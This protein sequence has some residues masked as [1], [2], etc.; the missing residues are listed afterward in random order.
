ML[1]M[2][3]RE[4]N[5]LSKN[6]PSDSHGSADIH[7][8]NLVPCFV[9]HIERVGK[10][11]KSR[12]IHQDIDAVPQAERRLD[13][14]LGGIIGRDIDRDRGSL[15]AD[16]P[17]FLGGLLERLQMAAYQNDV[18]SPVGQGFGD[19]ESYSHTRS[20]DN[21]AVSGRSNRSREM[22]G[23]GAFMKL[24]ELPDEGC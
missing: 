6:G 1:M 15:P 3:P 22:S 14:S 24:G 20:R 19:A 13:D 8:E 12:V 21:A 17:H 23:I 7:V 16:R 11:H 10:G 5:H 4:L 2:L 9:V 18:G